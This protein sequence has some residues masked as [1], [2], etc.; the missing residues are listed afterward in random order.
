[1]TAYTNIKMY[2][3]DLFIFN[4]TKCKNNHSKSRL[5]LNFSPHILNCPRWCSASLLKWKLAL[6]PSS[7]LVPPPNL[8]VWG[9]VRFSSVHVSTEATSSF[10]FSPESK[11]IPPLSL[12][13]ASRSLGIWYL[14][15][16][17][18]QLS[19][20]QF[21]KQTRRHLYLFELL[22]ST[23]ISSVFKT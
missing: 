15:L 1:M 23:D 9:W 16:G 20:P 12:I 22:F 14:I 5:K 3:F 7:H 10:V 6:L 17:R 2:T 11:H 18:S 21:S 4:L 19:P 13:T 8:N